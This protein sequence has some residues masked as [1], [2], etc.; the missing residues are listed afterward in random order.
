MMAITFSPAFRGELKALG[1]RSL[2]GALVGWSFNQALVGALVAVVLYLLRHLRYLLVLKAWTESPKIQDLPDPG[3]VWGE[4]FDSLL[5]L[6]SRNRKRKKR[7]ALMLTEFRASTE[8]LPDAA[9][10]LGP[11]GEIV[12]HNG[13]AERYLGF[14]SQDAGQRVINLIRH[15]AFTAY[16]E[17]GDY[18]REVE[19]PSA[20]APDRPLAFRLT[21][22]GNGQRLLLA[23][24]VSDRRRLE[25]VRRDFVANASH[26][27]RT[28]LTVLRGWLDMM[29]PD[30]DPTLEAWRAPLGEMRR[31]SARM[32]SLIGDMLKLARLEADQTRA[33]MAPFDT[34]RLIGKVV[35]DARALSGGRH[36]IRAEIDAGL[37][38]CGSSPDLESVFANLLTNAIRYTPTGGTI[39]VSWRQ[40]TPE[41]GACYAVR[42]TGIGIP[43]EDIPRLTERFYRVDV[44][45]SR[46]SGGTGLGLSIVR[47]VLDHHEGTLSIVSVPGQGSTFNACLPLVRVERH[48]IQSL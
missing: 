12:W 41:A 34:P 22:Y 5:D 16:Y 3:G 42:D 47:H 45:R 18:D 38:L 46:D 29:N 32:E 4:V 17:S 28:P 10:V 48:G 20:F 30:E 25:T 39:S 31:Q 26:E 35:A 19:C 7:L 11:R 9:V 24:D 23:R 44:A 27:M 40:D 37:W 14:K 36:E 8:A 33:V 21:P 43:P 15:P 13:A 1:L 2:I 6:Q